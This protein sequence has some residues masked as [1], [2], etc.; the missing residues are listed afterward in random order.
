MQGY[1]GEL[2]MDAELDRIDGR[3]AFKRPK[4]APGERFTPGGMQ[5]NKK[6]LGRDEKFGESTNEASSAAVICALA[7]SINLESGPTAAAAAAAAS[8]GRAST[9]PLSYPI[10][11]YPILSLHLPP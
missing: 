3:G 2:D 1:A 10:L 11:S 7:S 8:V 4:T 5:R 9:L 6:R